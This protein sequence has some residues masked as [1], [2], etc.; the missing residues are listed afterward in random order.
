MPQVTDVVKIHRK[1]LTKTAQYALEGTLKEN[2]TGIPKSIVTEDGPRYRCCIHKERAVLNDRI[3]IAL[4]QPL[5]TNLQE[6]AENAL[7]GKSTNMPI[8]QVLPAACDKCPIDKFIVTDACRNCVAHNCISACA[9]KAIMVVQNKAYMDKTKCSECGLCKRSCSYGAIIEISRPCE[10]SCNLQAITAGS[11]RRAVINYEKCVQCGACKAGCPFGAISDRSMLVQVINHLKNGSRVYAVVAPSIVGQFGVKVKTSQVMNALQKIGFHNVL[12]VA[13]GA[14]II[15][16]E[17]TKE[18]LTKAIEQP[19]FMTTSCCPAFVD[20]IEK[21]MPNIKN[22]VSTTVSPM[23]A[24]GKVIKNDDPDAVIVFIGPCIAK[25]SEIIK[26]PGIIDYV[27][28]FEELAALFEG[29]NINIT[30]IEERTYEST[31]SH[32]GNIFARAGGVLSAVLNTAKEMDPGIKILPHRCDGLE[33]CKTALANIRDGKI[34]ANFFEGMACE[35]GCIGGP[36]SLSD[37]RITSRLLDNHAEAL[38]VKTSPEN[39]RALEEVNKHLH[40]HY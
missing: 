38:T 23:I 35:G 7:S 16:L 1:I 19:G 13:M 25:K 26:H 21:H 34:N 33:N 15:A 10:R 24:I 20:M 30:E 11:D 28:S 14:D 4:S 39:K 17:E 9:K 36:G 27:V 2:I 5:G 8:M 18:F 3:A 29:A 32:D 6:A 40:W 31:A 22:Q 37:Y 12:E